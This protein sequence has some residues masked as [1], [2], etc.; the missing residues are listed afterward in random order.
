MP[1]IEEKGMEFIDLDDQTLSIVDREFKNLINT[2]VQKTQYLSLPFLD[3]VFV[4]P[5]TLMK[6]TNLLSGEAEMLY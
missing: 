2:S 5:V 1:S 3:T 4:V 6:G